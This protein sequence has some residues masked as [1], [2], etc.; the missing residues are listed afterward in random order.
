MKKRRSGPKWTVERLS[1]FAGVVETATDKSGMMKFMCM[2]D[3]GTMELNAE[4]FTRREL[5]QRI[6]SLAQLGGI[7]PC[8][9][10][11]GWARGVRAFDVKT[12]SGLDF[13][14][15][16][17]RGMDIA[18]ASYKGI[19]LVYQG[20]CGVVHPAHYDAHGQGWERGFFGG[21]L[22]TCG[23]T[24]IGAAGVDAGEALGLH[25]RQSY[26]PA[27]QICDLSG[28]RN[29][30]TYEMKL[31]GVIED[32][33][34]FGPKLRLTRTLRVRLGSPWIDVHDEVLNFGTR[35][36]P[37]AILYHINAGFPLLDDGAELH[38]TASG[39]EPYDAHSR[40]CFE[41]RLR[42]SGPQANFAEQN[43][44]HAIAADENGWGRAML[45]NR[46]LAGGLALAIRFEAAKLPWFTEWKMLQ[47]GDYVVGL[48]PCSVPCLNRAE[49]RKRGLLR[50]LE[51]GETE[52]FEVSIGVLEGQ[53]QIEAF[54]GM[55]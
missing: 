40:A 31:S 51:P 39:C 37:L 46:R 36:A 45:V 35:P 48:E 25:G 10:G 7:S 12:G 50:E 15:V 4:H 26:S 24:H 1:Y 34:L 38:L 22:T 20:A 6:G 23:L 41:D 27:V 47:E 33:V 3:V 19:N 17:D 30:E 49:L 8:V 52:R 2:Q 43:F 16:A 54:M 44:L 29:D 13:T 11:E 32:A 55:H 14:V 21:L 42:F 18:R 53:A 5:E 9:L 28:W